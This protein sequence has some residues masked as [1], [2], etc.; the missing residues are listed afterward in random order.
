MP[1]QLEAARAWSTWEWSTSALIPEVEG[2]TDEKCLAFARIENHYFV[3]EGFLDT[4]DQLLTNANRTC[5]Y[6]DRDH[7]RSLRRDLPGAQCLGA[8]QGDATRGATHHPRRRTLDGRA[9]NHRRADRRHQSL[10]Q[11]FERLARI[12]NS[13][14]A[15]RHPVIP[16]EVEGTPRLSESHQATFYR[17]ESELRFKLR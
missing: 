17:S 15:Q 1:A 16:T 2:G 12:Q 3:N 5:Q 8:A 11:T 4:P 9:R 13:R 7:P 10:R 6:P 14:T